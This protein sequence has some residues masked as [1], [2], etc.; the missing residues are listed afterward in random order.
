MS[1]QALYRKWRPDRF[2]DI[3][4][5]D[6]VITTLKNQIISGRIG[7]AYLFS[8]T[9]GTGKTSTAKIFSR[10]VNCPNARANNGNPCNICEVC[11]AIKSGRVMNVMEIDA[12]SNNGVDNIRDIREE[13]EY[14][15]VTGTYKVYI[16]D[17]VH[18]LS[19]GAF[20]A[21]LKTLEEPPQYVI[22][23]LATTDPERIPATIL[24]RCQRYDFRRISAVAIENHLS[25][26]LLKEG[27]KAEIEAVS[28][29]ARAADGSMRDA[30]SILDQC[31]SMHPEEG[32]SYEDVLSILGSLD[33]SVYS[34]LL[35]QILDRDVT[36]VLKTVEDVLNSGADV[37]RLITD[38]IWY[39][40]NV[41]LSGN[42][43]NDSSDLVDLSLETL[44]IARTDYRRLSKSGL[45]YILES[46]AQ[47]SN[48]AR[49]SPQKRVL[50][51][52]ELILMATSNLKENDLRNSPFPKS[53]RSE[54]GAKTEK[55]VKSD[56][57]VKVEK[58]VKSDED[59]NSKAT[60]D[61]LRKNW[62]MMIKKLHPSNRSLFSQ[63][64]LSEENN[65]IV[66]IFKNNINYRMAAG[67]KVENGVL[68]LRELS[69]E[70]TGHE[71][72]LVA[73]ASRVLETDQYMDTITDEE[74]ARI[75]FPVNFES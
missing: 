1:Y 72:N 49:F 19:I 67:N 31:M 56:D 12:A 29:I 43:E 7:H 22:F 9:R 69:K 21:L 32:L 57:K 3:I 50:L 45:I 52:V 55:V 70:L 35:G 48:R 58:V 47:L 42:I 20:N 40:R 71:V 62:Q 38:F 14:P 4:G 30:L 5:Q 53:D 27:L 75:N 68:K 24:S 46:L 10:A 74:L 36:G 66:M 41:L 54:T 39:L 51:E 8:G 33:T 15:P 6:A 63:V 28:Y 73:R 17:E 11:A 18:M 34:R 26:I 16:I 37:M 44:N 60:I 59:P 61:I 2:D 65:A 25:D 64:I 23:I 13:V